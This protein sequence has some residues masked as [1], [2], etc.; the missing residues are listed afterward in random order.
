[1]SC[2]PEGF[3]VQSKIVKK[4]TNPV[5]DLDCQFPVPKGSCEPQQENNVSHHVEEDFLELEVWDHDKGPMADD[6]L[7]KVKVPLS[8]LDVKMTSEAW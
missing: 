3:Q 8:Q 4:T 7:G 5:W 1:M 2:C 6:F